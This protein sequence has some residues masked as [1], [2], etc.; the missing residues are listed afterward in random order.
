MRACCGT[1]P[2]RTTEAGLSRFTSVMLPALSVS[3]STLDFRSSSSWKFSV[4]PSVK[5]IETKLGNPN[6]TW[7]FQDLSCASQPIIV[8][9]YKDLRGWDKDGN[10]IPPWDYLLEYRNLH[11]Q[12]DERA[13]VLIGIHP[14]P[15]GWSKALHEQGVNVEV[16]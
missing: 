9:G 8:A 2:R 6:S 14:E 7:S 3:N 4:V 11:C 1:R 13:Y 10:L 12:P 15:G 16:P 5:S